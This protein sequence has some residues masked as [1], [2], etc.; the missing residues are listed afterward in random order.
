[1]PK[2]ISGNEPQLAALLRAQHSVIARSQ[3]LACGLTRDAIMHRIRPGGPWQRLL[4]AVYLAHT[5]S[6]TPEQRDMAAHL[7]A[8]RPSVLTG[9]AAMRVLRISAAIPELIDV[10]VPLDN[11]RRSAGFVTLHRTSRMPGTVVAK[12]RREYAMAPR[13]IADA[14][15]GM[16]DL[17]EV[18][19]LVAGAVQHGHCRVS[20][21]S[22]EL[23]AGPV[24]GSA[25]LRRVLAEVA[26]G[27]RSAAEADLKDLIKRFRLP[28]PL[29]NARL[30]DL[31]GNYIAR[32]DAW[33]PGAGV[34]AEVDSRQWHLSPADWE[35][36]MARHDRMSQLGI[37]V[38][39]FS[40]QQL[41]A[42]PQAVAGSI[43]RALKTGSTRPKLPITTRR[44]A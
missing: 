36:T 39:H 15:R 14:A 11:Q 41:R 5:G 40:P 30:Y 42:E 7:Y 44:A 4:P 38:L 12:G 33:W 28:T 18:R 19:A 29:Y 16:T 37:L 22:E 21:L 27:V 31:D 25:R 17:G 26:A 20:L 6:P 3:A 8:G 32:P 1:M 35:Q 34:A 24:R 10:L 23:K 13:A 43:S 9:Q 2:R